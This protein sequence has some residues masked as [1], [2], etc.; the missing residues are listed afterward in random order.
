[1]TNE[2][3]PADEGIEA[4]KRQ[5]NRPYRAE[6]T[7]TPTGSPVLKLTANHPTRRYR[8]R[9]I[10]AFI[11][12]LAAE[13]ERRSEGMGARWVISPE[14]INARVVI[15]LTNDHETALANEFVANIIADN[16]LT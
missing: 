1:M 2:R 11:Y 3:S 4:A 15:E 8:H 7:R 5:A 6:V 13:M 12:D 16:N 10:A 9:Q 14:P